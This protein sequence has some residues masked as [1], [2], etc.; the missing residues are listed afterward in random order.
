MD[1]GAELRLAGRDH[2][3]CPEHGIEILC[4]AEFTWMDSIVVAP[5]QSAGLVKQ[6]LHMSGVTHTTRRKKDIGRTVINADIF[7]LATGQQRRAR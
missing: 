6:W 1:D 5:C 2:T 3:R 4:E 7:I